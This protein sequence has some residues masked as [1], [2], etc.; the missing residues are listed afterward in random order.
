MFDFHLIV[1]TN[2]TD[3]EFARTWSTSLTKLLI[4]LDN[5]VGMGIDKDIWSDKLKVSMTVKY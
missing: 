3:F 5:S 2:G 1:I 4:G